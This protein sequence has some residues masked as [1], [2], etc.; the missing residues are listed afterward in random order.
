MAIL[1]PT[2][3]LSGLLSENGGT[4]QS[5]PVSNEWMRATVPFSR[6]AGL[7]MSTTTASRT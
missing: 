3:E 2:F 4:G 7:A 6:L 1:F 5:G